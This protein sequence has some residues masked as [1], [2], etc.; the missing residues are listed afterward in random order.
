MYR[1]DLRGPAANKVT[2]LETT[3]RQELLRELGKVAELVE[4]RGGS[5]AFEPVLNLWFNY[6]RYRVLYTVDVR[7]QVLSFVDLLPKEPG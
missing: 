5:V 2:A 6:G 3:L 4:D 7:K 1:V